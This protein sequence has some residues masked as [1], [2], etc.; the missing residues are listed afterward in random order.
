VL[1]LPPFYC[2]LPSTQLQVGFIGY[3]TSDTRPSPL[4]SKRFFAPVVATA[5]EMKEEAAKL[6]IGQTGCGD[7]NGMAALEGLVA[8]IEVRFLNLTIADR[9]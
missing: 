5:K 8:A 2:L 6:G 3:A 9:D 4:L 7:G 1:V